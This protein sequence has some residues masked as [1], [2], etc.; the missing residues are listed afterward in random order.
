M[1][2]LDS[3]GD[4]LLLKRLREGDPY[5]FTAIFSKYYRSLVLYCNSFITDRRECEDIV[6]NLFVK[7]W[8]NRETLDIRSLKSFLLRCVRHD[9]LDAIKH[10][11]IEDSYAASFIIANDLNDLAIDSYFL[12]DELEELIET[13]LLSLDAKSVEAFRMSRWDGMKYDDI[14]QKMNV[15]R[16]TVEVRVTNVIKKLRE[17]IKTLCL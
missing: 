9:C 12:Y 17:I 6:M 3:S 1:N 10:R 2:E 11:K 15:S 7:L 5:A 4:E 8:E 14:A 13:A 16:R